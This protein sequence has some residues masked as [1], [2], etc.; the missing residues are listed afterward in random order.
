MS[1]NPIEHNK[2][3]SIYEINDRAA[4]AMVMAVMIQVLKA[5]MDTVKAIHKIFAEAIREQGRISKEKH[6]AW[7]VHQTVAR[8]HQ[9]EIEHRNREATQVTTI[10]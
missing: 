3:E 4:K 7:Q 2:L 9:L 10:H 5:H 1:V 8:H 6:E